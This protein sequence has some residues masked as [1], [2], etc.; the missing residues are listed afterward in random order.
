VN[1]TIEASISIAAPREAV[2]DVVQ[3]A[4]RRSVWDERV[5]RAWLEGGAA[6]GKGSRLFV[7]ARVV[8]PLTVTTELEYVLFER[9]SRTAV[10]IV[11]TRGPAWMCAGGGTWIFA[12]VHGGTRFTTRF[13]YAVRGG[14][15]GRLLDRTVARPF[16]ERLTHASLVNLKRLLEQGRGA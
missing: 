14:V 13:G 7:E 5:L 10:K 15:F 1:T 3:D 2:F 8:G 6:P 11:S 9:P 12:E 16:F 4:A